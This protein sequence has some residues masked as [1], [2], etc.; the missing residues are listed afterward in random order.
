[1]ILMIWAA[2]TPSAWD[3]SRTET[4]DCTVTGPVGCVDSRRSLRGVSCR[5]RCCLASGRGRAAPLSI[6]T[7]RRRRWPGA[8]WRGRTG[9]FGRLGPDWSAIGVSV[10]ARELRLDGDR[11]SERSVEGPSGRGPLEAGQPP[12]G[13][14]APAGAARGDA[15]HSL[16]SREADELRLRRLA[17]AADAGPDRLR[18]GAHAAVVPSSCAW[19]FASPSVA[20]S[21]PS[22]S[23]AASASSSG[24]DSW[25][26]CSLPSAGSWSA[27][28]WCAATP[29]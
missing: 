26:T 5:S 18:S 22:S 13:V 14:D 12:A 16:R 23:S 2:G 21:A 15:Q 20:A 6:T 28:S 8:P 17:P 4:P 24:S 27:S 3:R 19:R 25:T 10:E 11:A 9:R 29:Q 1:M 7:R